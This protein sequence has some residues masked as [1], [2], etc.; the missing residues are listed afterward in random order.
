MFMKRLISFGLALMLSAFV[1]H[2]SE[3]FEAP[4][5]WRVIGTEKSYPDLV[6]ALRA[7]VKKEE[8]G[9]VTQASATVGAK[10]QGITI[11]GNTVIG[12][13]RNDFARRM[14]EASIPAGIEAPI[15][16]Y[17]TEN[18]DKTATLSWKTP[19]FVFEPYFDDGGDALIGLAEELDAIF[20]R[21]AD[22]ATGNL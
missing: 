2:A 6:A 9:L 8:M 21:I 10:S 18:T 3:G 15:R 19:S 14:L 12:V 20:Q 7:A 22:R 4:E 11:P 17:V 13:Y 16:F 5:G 1:A